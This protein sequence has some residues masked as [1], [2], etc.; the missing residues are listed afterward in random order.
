MI[1][2][3]RAA[4]VVGVVGRGEVTAV[5]DDVEAEE[6]EGQEAGLSKG[7]ERQVSKWELIRRCLVFSPHT[8]HSTSGET[9]K[10]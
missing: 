5:A 9:D 8:G 2:G 7:A 6:W 4:I 10:I 1:P 3:W